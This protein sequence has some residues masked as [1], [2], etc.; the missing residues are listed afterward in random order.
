MLTAGPFLKNSGPSSV[1]HA[2]TP[3]RMI[4]R[5]VTVRPGTHLRAGGQRPWDQ[6]HGTRAT[7]AGVVV[8]DSLAVEG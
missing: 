6:G 1:E 7:V 2:C 5:L 3:F 4:A 8:E